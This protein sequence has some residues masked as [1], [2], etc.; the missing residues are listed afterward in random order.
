MGFLRHLGM[1]LFP[2]IK[3]QKH[4]LIFHLFSLGFSLSGIYLEGNYLSYISLIMKMPRSGSEND[5]V[6]DR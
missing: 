3:Q 1:M 5:D 6:K 4:Q 2:N